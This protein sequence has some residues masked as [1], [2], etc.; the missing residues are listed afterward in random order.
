MARK[1]SRSRRQSAKRCCTEARFNAAMRRGAMKTA[2]Q[3]FMLG[4]RNKC[5]WTRKIHSM[6]VPKSWLIEGVL[7]KHKVPVTKIIASRVEIE[8]IVGFPVPMKRR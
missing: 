6:R 4:F 2:R 7:R 5:S 3:C 1:R 8:D